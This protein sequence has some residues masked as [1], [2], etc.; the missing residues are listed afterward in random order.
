MGGVYTLRDPETGAVVRTG[1]TYSLAQREA[2]HASDPVLG[3]S[4]SGWNT[5]PMTST[6]G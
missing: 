3:N 5:G 1:Q 4:S 2:Q 6:H